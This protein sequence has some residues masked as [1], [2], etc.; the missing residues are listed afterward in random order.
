MIL[1]EPSHFKWAN[2]I[3][4][5]FGITRFKKKNKKKTILLIDEADV[6]FD[7]DFYGQL[8]RPAIRLHDNSIR[9]LLFLIWKKVREQPTNKRALLNSIL[10]SSEFKACVNKYGNLK[11][12]L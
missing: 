8:Y 10:K 2:E 7:S 1:E 9:D 12:I 11:G 3:F 6:F 4:I 5:H